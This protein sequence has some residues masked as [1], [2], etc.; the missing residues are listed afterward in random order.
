MPKIPLYNQGLGP[1][2]TQAPASLSRRADSGAFTGVGRSL[3]S[4]GEQV[5]DIAF[6][7]GQE[8]KRKEVEDQEVILSEEVARGVEEVKSNTNL[9]NAA[10]AKAN[11]TAL[12]EKTFAKIDGL[13]MTQ[14]QKRTLKNGV[15]KTYALRGIDAEQAAYSRGLGNSAER[16]AMQIDKELDALNT[17]PPGDPRADISRAN[18]DK[19]RNNARK[20]GYIHLLPTGYQTADAT[21]NLMAGRQTTAL[22]SDQ[23]A[24][25]EQIAA[26]RAS[27][28][29]DYRNGNISDSV[30]RANDSLLQNRLDH[31]K[32][33]GNVTDAE[34]LQPYFDD[35]DDLI[36]RDDVT[37]AEI[38]AE[39]EAIENRTGKYSEIE[40]GDRR[41]LIS[42]LTEAESRFS[43]VKSIELAETIQVQKGNIARTGVVTPEARKALEELQLINPQTAAEKYIEVESAQ[44]VFQAIGNTELMSPSDVEQ[45]IVSIVDEAEELR[46]KGDPA[47]NRR[48]L[49]LENAAQFAR[50]AELAR[51]ERIWVLETMKYPSF[52]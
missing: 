28:T 27:L 33:L 22:L 24:T 43:V 9:V 36:F 19:L 42:R 2:Q 30:F 20:A 39:R 40:K 47:D 41:S 34:R 32:N 4:F 46:K 51:R 13:D 29:E 26:A 14:G 25:E 21:A 23:D 48:I 16:A 38:V 45:R 10:Q 7:F 44:Y 3:A 11:I 12:Q 5:G 8:Q 49:V 15:A 37:Y 50:E 6:R 17:Y 52:P 18:I 35:I 1:V 31:L